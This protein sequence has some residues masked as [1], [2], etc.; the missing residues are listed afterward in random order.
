MRHLSS[1]HHRSAS[2]PVEAGKEMIVDTDPA[3]REREA[4]LLTAAPVPWS[5]QSFLSSVARHVTGA[6]LQLLMTM[7]EQADARTGLVTISVRELAKSARFPRLS[8]VHVIETD[9]LVRQFRSFVRVSYRRAAGD[10][11]EVEGVS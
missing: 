4:S 8:L 11:P 9:D 6:A 5:H 10:R 3:V 1:V 2:S 7:L